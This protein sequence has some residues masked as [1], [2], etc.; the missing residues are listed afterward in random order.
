MSKYIKGLVQSELE[1]TIQEHQLRDFL[2]LSLTGIGGTDNNEIRGALKEKGI[3]VYVVKNSLF[4]RALRTRGMEAATDLFNGPCAV[5]YGGDSIV[6]VAK[7]ITEWTKKLDA[8][9]VKGA[10]LDGTVLG[11]K[12][13]LQLAKMP[14]RREIQAQLATM[15]LSP[16]RILAG[17]V[18]SPASRI[19]GC[20][21][22]IIEKNEKQA[23]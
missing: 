12:G 19:A 18:A 8:L 3:S 21:K 22:Y 23:A 20:I 5:V 4:K 2:I 15:L 7:E 14:T 6:D 1:K 11:E 10:F 13:A 9:Q 17:C 16:A